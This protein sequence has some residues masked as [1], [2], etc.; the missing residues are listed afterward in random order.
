MIY[1][2]MINDIPVEAEFSDQDVQEIYI[3]LLRKLRQMQENK[4]GRILIFL[5]APPGVGK[6]TLAMFLQMLSE[7]TE[8]LKKVTAIGIDGFHHYETYLNTH[9]TVRDGTEIPLI[10]VKGAPETFDLQKLTAGIQK[11]AAG[12]DCM[13]PTYSRILHDPVENAVKVS[14][15]IILLEGNYLLLDAPGWRDLKQYADMTV[16]LMP[17]D[18]EILKE[19]LVNRKAASGFSP[20]EAEAHVTFSDLYNADLCM[21]HALPADLTI[22]S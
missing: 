8:G 1:S 19:R 18:R 2:A 11:I 20:E 3:P 15:D 7:T 5:A 13:W 17:P 16:S 14:G 9:T 12:E 21:E 22:H 4:K 6:T 10:K